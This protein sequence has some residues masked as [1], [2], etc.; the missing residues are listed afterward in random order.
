MA[1]VPA[2]LLSK[3]HSA[4][5]PRQANLTSPQYG[6][7]YMWSYKAQ[8]ETPWSVSRDR[9]LWRL[10]DEMTMPRIAAH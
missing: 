5:M 6:L 3:S 2:D 8:S 1:T 9:E 7:C 10:A 4:L